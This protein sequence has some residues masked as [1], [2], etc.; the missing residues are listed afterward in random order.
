MVKLIE[1]CNSVGWTNS[2]GIE[3]IVANLK[4]QW[5]EEWGM[6]D[7]RVND[8]ARS[9]GIAIRVYDKMW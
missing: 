7:H 9:C 5:S 8:T 1:S 6:K 4:Q 3:R 2:K